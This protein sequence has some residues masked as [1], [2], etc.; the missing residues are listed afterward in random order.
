ML[1]P[2]KYANHFDRRLP[3]HL[4]P[5]E[6]E[7]SALAANG[8]GPFRSRGV[9]KFAS[10]IFQLAEEQRCLAAH[11]FYTPCHT[12]WYLLYFDNRDTAVHRNHWKFG[13]HVHL[14]CSLWP[15]LSL[16]KTW[17]KVLEGDLSFPSKV[18]L[19]YKRR[20]TET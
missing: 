18:H 10:K 19:R 4:L 13:A 7:R 17:K 8:V 1:A 12:H 20:G 9:S 5:N 11:L 2:Y 6:A 14:L 16:E 15:N 3:S